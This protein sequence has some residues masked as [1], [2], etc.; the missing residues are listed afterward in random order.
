MPA[1]RPDK[2]LA[3]AAWWA[4]TDPFTAE[5]AESAPEFASLRA[6]VAAMMRSLTAEAKSGAEERVGRAAEQVDAAGPRPVADGLDTRAVLAIAARFTES[7]K[8]ADCGRARG[9]ADLVLS[10]YGPCAAPVKG[11]IA[12]NAGRLK[13]HGIQ[14]L[15]ARAPLLVLLGVWLAIG[16]TGAIGTG[17]W[18]IGLLALTGLGFYAR[19]RHVRF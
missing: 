1:N 12:L 15:W 5:S 16:L 2:A 4:R 11:A 10:K 6:E 17:I 7:A 19:I 9:L 14:R 8:L 13:V 3:A 18:P